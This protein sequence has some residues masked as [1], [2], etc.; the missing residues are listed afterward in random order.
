MDE[1]GDPQITI[2]TRFETDSSGADQ[3]VA[4]SGRIGDAAK[5]VGD[6][7]DV[8]STKGNRLMEDLGNRRGSQRAAME[9]FEVLRGGGSTIE[10]LTGLL[11]MF[12]L[13]AEGLDPMLLIVGAVSLALTGLIAKHED[14]SKKTK[15]STDATNDLKDAY[16]NIIPSIEAYKRLLEDTGAEEK[17]IQDIQKNNLADI[18]DEMEEK[19][20]SLELDKQ[21]AIEKARQTYLD[22]SLATDD[23]DE[24]K[25][26]KARFEATQKDIEG[27]TGINTANFDLK[28][29]LD[30]VAST[31]SQLD[32]QNQQIQALRDQV[33]AME[34]QRTTDAQFLA[35]LGI[36]VNDK[37]L[38][39]MAKDTVDATTGQA[40]KEDAPAIN[41]LQKQIDAAL[42]KRIDAPE[43]LKE[44]AARLSTPGLRQQYID[45]VTKGVEVA[46]ANLDRVQNIQNRLP[47]SSEASQN[48]LEGQVK[49]LQG[50]LYETQ[51]AL[52][53][54]KPQVELA[55]KGVSLANLKDINDKGEASLDQSDTNREIAKSDAEAAQRKQ[56]EQAAATRRQETQEERTNRS[57][58][59]G[60]EGSIEST[61]NKPMIDAMRR[62]VEMFKGKQGESSQLAEIAALTN[63]FVDQMRQ[64]KQQTTTAIGDLRRKIDDTRNRE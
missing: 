50:T 64:Y 19:K 42:Q 16:D 20:K 24:R 53:Q 48:T 35:P 34:N 3:A 9:L 52:E 2:V 31:K 56:R 14:V 25:R 54:L 1:T 62:V 18:K 23:P 30:E 13:T 63:V 55:Q 40:R 58:I 15:G 59:E 17:T 43:Y 61:G 36:T 8:A 60:L 6:E 5:T 49:E 51:R 47:Q 46:Q 33:A 44:N 29:K 45:E 38:L 37:G 28:E 11:R 32:Q 4:D 27:S 10:G 7:S 21:I 22:K 39:V 41:E 57:Q 12:L 26:L